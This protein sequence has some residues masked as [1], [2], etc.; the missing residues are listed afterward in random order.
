MK[1]SAPSEIITG[2]EIA[3]AAWKLMNEC[4]RDQDNQGGVMSGIGMF[5]S[6]VSGLRGFHNGLGTSRLITN[7]VEGNR[8]ER[9]TG[10][11][12]ALLRS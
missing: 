5:K 12:S 9:N 11:H 3:R 2:K 7:Y 6:R 1:G 4:V 10:D 8:S